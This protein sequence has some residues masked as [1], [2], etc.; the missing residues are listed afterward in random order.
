[1]PISLPSPNDNEKQP[2]RNRNEKQP[3]RNEKKYGKDAMRN[4]IEMK[5]NLAEAREEQA[6][7]CLFPCPPQTME[8][9]F[10]DPSQS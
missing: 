1:L 10:L 6:I 9:R 4:Q 2:N 7:Y 3:N 5:R 8:G